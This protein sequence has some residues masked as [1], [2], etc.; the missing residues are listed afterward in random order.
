M[1]VLGINLLNVS[2]TA[3]LV[4]Y[5]FI[6][7]FM[8]LLV[9]M[10]RPKQE[11][12]GAAFGANTTD[13]L[14]GAR[15]TNVLQKGTV[16]CA[17]LFF[18]LTL[19]L[20]ILVQKKNHVN[21]LTKAEEVK[22]EEVAAPAQPESLKNE[23]QPTTTSDPVV[24]PPVTDTPAPTSTGTPVPAEEKAAETPAPA[25]SKPEGTPAETKPADAAET[26]PAEPAA[27]TDKKPEP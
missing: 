10:Q 21:S 6:C 18:V 26:K 1:S 4:V 24:V 7:F 12:L 27:E 5:V 8:V 16:Y 17:V 20:A 3:L 15:T 14:F 2:I 22:T 23:L 19:G 9:L 11:G 13:Q 25:E